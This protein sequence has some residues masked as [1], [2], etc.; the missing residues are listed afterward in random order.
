MSGPGTE[1]WS[2]ERLVRSCLR[3]DEAAW[4][5][6]VDRYSRFVWAIVRR[7]DVAESDQGDAF[8]LVWVD[9][10]NDLEKLESPGAVRSWIGSI[11]HHRSYHLRTP[12]PSRRLAARS[13]RRLRITSSRRTPP[14]RTSSLELEQ[15]QIAREVVAELSEQCRKLLE[16]LFLEDPPRPY[17]EVAEE[18]GM[19]VG[20]IGF[21]RGRCLEKLRRRLANRGVLGT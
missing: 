17:K 10:Y 14:I 4:R 13:P 19:A 11:A 16:L 2:D 20:S 1:S 9:V 18:L 12:R 21:T 15:Q 3:G 5:A 6:L 8:Q 7:G